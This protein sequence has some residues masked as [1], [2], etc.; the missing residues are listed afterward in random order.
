M[1]AGQVTAT[2]TYLEMT[3]RARAAR[4]RAGAGRR[5]ACRSPRRSAT[6]SSGA[7]CIRPWARP[8]TGWI[9]CRGQTMRSGAYL[10]DPAVSL[11]L[12][13]RRRRG[14]RLLRAAPRG[15][16]RQRRD[17]VLRT[18]ARVH[19]TRP[20]RIPA[21]R[22]R[23]ARLG[24]RR[25]PGLAPHLQLRSPVRDPELSR[26]RVHRVQDRAVRRRS[27]GLQDRATENTDNHGT[28]I[29][30]IGRVAFECWR[31]GRTPALAGAR[32]AWACTDRKH[33]QDI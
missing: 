12:T 27:P 23:R 17:R 11:W 24:L 25:A 32:M 30:R 14:R 2:R 7:T 3:D 20:G 13:D 31:K 21:D 10:S 18:L 6:P 28:R 5:R 4:C 1:S 9:G 15:R 19:R 16:R 29:S 26:S 8:T 33:D 22:S